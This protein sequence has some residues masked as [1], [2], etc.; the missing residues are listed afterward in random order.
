M[1]YYN[2]KLTGTTFVYQRSELIARVE[3]V[4]RSMESSKFMPHGFVDRNDLWA[5]D[6][7]N[8]HPAKE[9]LRQHHVAI[10]EQLDNRANYAYGDEVEIGNEK[11]ANAIRN[12]IAAMI[13]LLNS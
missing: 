8:A 5:T 2:S 4:S 9:E 12:H 7:Y 6:A 13:D 11:I 10:L 1:F 3:R